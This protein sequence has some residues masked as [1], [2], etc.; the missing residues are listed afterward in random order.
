MSI[1]PDG[2]SVTAGRTSRLAAG[3]GPGARARSR[4]RAGAAPGRAGAGRDTAGVRRRARLRVRRPPAPAS[5]PTPASP[6]S[7]TLK[8]WRRDFT[9]KT[10]GVFSAA[11][12]AGELTQS[13]CS[14]WQHD[15]RDCACHY[16]A[17]N[18]P[19]VV[20]AEDRPTDDVLALGRIGRPAP[21]RNPDRLAAIGPRP[22]SSGRRD[23]QLPGEPAVPDGPLRDQSALGGAVD[24]PGRQGV[25]GGLSAPLGRPGESV[26]EPRANS[27]R[28]SLSSRH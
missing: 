8:G 6:P 11:Y 22:G 10:T 2:T 9:D 4:D 17:S 19:D 26:R 20:L 24:R 25:A 16:W 3:A 28:R 15:F 1:Q 23:R 7:V 5:L 18:H 12:V 27:P 21:G 14:P 13:L